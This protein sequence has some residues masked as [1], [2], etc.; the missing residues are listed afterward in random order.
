MKRLIAACLCGAGLVLAGPAGASEGTEPD[1]ET[2]KAGA[3]EVARSDLQSWITLD[4]LVYAIR[5]QNARHAG[6]DDARIAALDARWIGEGRGGPMAADLLSR[7]ASILLRDRRE[8]A[9]GLITEIMVFDRHGLLVAL[10]D[11]T[12][13]YL[14][15]DEP[16][17]LRTYPEG[18]G[19]I[20]V[21][22]PEPDESTGRVQIDVS[23]TVSDP[24]TGEAIGGTTISVDP[25][26]LA[27]RE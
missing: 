8:E 24:E 13:D 12:E 25:E 14:Q 9:A 7:Q 11:W 17:Y 5:E 22:D 16:K 2:L 27:A 26:R 1:V 18:P 3:L 4:Y 15:G 6:L 21:A 10:S 19:T 20:H 23:L